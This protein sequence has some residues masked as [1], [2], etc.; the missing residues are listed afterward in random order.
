MKNAVRFA[1]ILGL[2][3]VA[4]ALGISGVYE[5]TRGRIREKEKKAFQD[6]LGVIFPEASRFAAFG[7]DDSEGDGEALVERLSSGEI[8]GVAV[9]DS[10]EVG[11]FVVAEKQGYSSRIK[12]LVGA[13]PDMSIRAIRILYAAETPGLGERAKEVKSDKTVWEGEAVAAALGLSGGEAS[14]SREPWFQE[15]FR[16]KTLEQLVVVKDPDAQGIQA[17][18][19]ATV[20]SKAVTDCVRLALERIRAEK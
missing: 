16:E 20:T 9:A 5:L 19:A 6:A 17:I 10:G 8:V 4:A 3:A 15:Q 14:A 11:Y 1:I 7:E 18:T 2:I 13:K 12:I